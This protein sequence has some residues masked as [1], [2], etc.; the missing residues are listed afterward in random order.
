MTVNF[1][2]FFQDSA[3]PVE[4][5]KNNSVNP[6]ASFKGTDDNSVS[7]KQINIPDSSYMTV[8]LH[9]LYV[10]NMQLLKD[11][12]TL[13]Q[14]KESRIFVNTEVRNMDWANPALLDDALE[15]KI[16]P[17]DI[18]TE[19]SKKTE[20]VKAMLSAYA[21]LKTKFNTEDVR[22]HI[23]KFNK[24]ESEI[25]A[26]LSKK[27]SDISPKRQYD[28]KAMI[29]SILRNVNKDNEPLLRKLLDDE[30]FNNVEISKAL[31]SLD[32]NKDMSYAFAVLEMAQ[33]VGYDKEFSMPLAILMSE[34]NERNMGMI[35]KMLGEQD[36]LSENNDFVANNLMNFLRDA[37]SGLSAVY[38]EDD[39]I[40]LFE[41]QELISMEED[42][43]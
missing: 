30:N 18:F 29:L 35:V 20:D 6:Q 32:K 12:Y 34:A 11:G 19:K 33:N 9:P 4:K 26:F 5:T 43:E 41:V 3:L 15:G 13:E 14:I 36:F 2:N 25:A 28:S 27:G 37:G 7:D 38:E 23:S 1:S 24:L 39:D 21:A 8:Q 16:T 10:L 31:M 17:N 40:T 42:E 22:Q